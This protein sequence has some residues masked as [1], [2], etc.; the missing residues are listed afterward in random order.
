MP[1]WFVWLLPGWGGSVWLN[2]LQI[3]RSC[4]STNQCNTTSLTGTVLCYDILSWA[5]HRA[6]VRLAK[7]FKWVK[8]ETKK[9]KGLHFEDAAQIL[10]LFPVYM[11]RLRDTWESEGWQG[12]SREGAEC[13]L[14]DKQTHFTFCSRLTKK[15]TTIYL[16]QLGVSLCKT[17]IMHQSGED[18]YVY[19]CIYGSRCFLYGY[20]VSPDLN[21]SVL[22]QL[23][24]TNSHLCN[25]I[26]CFIFL[27]SSIFFLSLMVCIADIRFFKCQTEKSN[28]QWLNQPY[29]GWAWFQHVIQSLNGQ[30]WNHWIHT[31]T[32]YKPLVLHTKHGVKRQHCDNVSVR[33]LNWKYCTCP[34]FQCRLSPQSWSCLSHIYH[35]PHNLR[36]RIG[37][38]EN[39]VLPILNYSFLMSFLAYI[40]SDISEVR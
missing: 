25:L 15:K 16:W 3:S 39:C 37:L 36:H 27:S 32:N 18:V 2:D 9:K 7:P 30:E 17:L 40:K 38:W 24:P 34:S 22:S 19:V 35:L 26:Y 10:F 28:T 5:E 33:E 23:K 21:I 6:L 29:A 1:F 8:Q 14:L 11:H 12:D 13:H 31:D 20:N 4:L